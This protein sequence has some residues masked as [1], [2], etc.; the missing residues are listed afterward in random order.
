MESDRARWRICTW[1]EERQELAVKVAQCAIV[2]EKRLI[3]LG[4]AFEDGCIG[5][6][7]L[8]QAD[9]SANKEDAHLHGL[10][11]AQNIRGHQRPVFGEDPRSKVS[12]A[13]PLRTDHKL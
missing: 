13:M 2:L 12:A 3:D 10:L 9:E 5:G 7:L 8:A 1:F 11:A 6:D 4:E